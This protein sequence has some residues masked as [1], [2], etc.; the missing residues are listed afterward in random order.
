MWSSQ[1]RASEWAHFSHFIDWNATWL[2]FNNNQKS[3]NNFTNP[4][5]AEL[6]AATVAE[7]LI[8]CNTIKFPFSGG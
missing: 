6:F 7:F 2:Y 1:K 4:S 8:I 5:K 3:S